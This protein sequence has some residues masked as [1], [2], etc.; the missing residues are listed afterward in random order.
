MSLAQI[1]DFD[2]KDLYSFLETN[3][4]GSASEWITIYATVLRHFLRGETLYLKKICYDIE[5]KCGNKMV[6]LE[7]YVSLKLRIGLLDSSLSEDLVEKAAQLARSESEWSGELNMLLGAVCAGRGERLKA[8]DYYWEAARG[9]LKIGAYRKEA[10]AK[11]NVLVERSHL[12]PNANLIAE[13]HDLYRYALRKEIRSTLVAGICLL[14]ISREYQILGATLAALRYCE[15]ARRLLEIEFGTCPYFLSLA[16]LC[17][18]YLE[19]KRFI[20]AKLAYELALAAPFEE[21]QSALRVLEK[22][23]DMCALEQQN[24]SKLNSTWAERRL[25]WLSRKGVETP[26]K[27]STLEQR[28]LRS[29]A[30]GPKTK[31]ELIA[32]LYGERLSVEIRIS[33]FESLLKTLRKKQ[34]S[35]VVFENGVYRLAH[36]F[37]EVETK[38]A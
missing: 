32:N 25:D 4:E 9:F 5:S 21:V 8:K 28:L 23:F 15:R 24:P 2:L 14:N 37:F 16:H 22:A 3:T 35:L 30:A 7:L 6:P 34:T 10:R 19:L 18:I 1:L 36:T 29:L 27:L 31:L 26:V 33:R 12:D 13:Y 11:L 17:H 20:E 38:G